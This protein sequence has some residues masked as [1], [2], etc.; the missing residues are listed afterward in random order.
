MRFYLSTNARHSEFKH[1]TINL[2]GRLS[3]FFTNNYEEQTQMEPTFVKER[4]ITV[5][6]FVDPFS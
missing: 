3:L 5:T 1:N 6:I 2:Q 4:E